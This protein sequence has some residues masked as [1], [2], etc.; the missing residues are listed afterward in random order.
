MGMKN[1]KYGVQNAV[2]EVI[3]ENPFKTSMG[4]ADTN[5][6]PEKSNSV[7]K[8]RQRTQ[9]RASVSSTNLKNKHISPFKRTVNIKENIKKQ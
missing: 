5:P 2:D 1:N 3:N 4:N 6:S 7:L 8:L 9:S